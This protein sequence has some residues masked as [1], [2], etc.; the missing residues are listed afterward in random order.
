MGFYFSKIY[1]TTGKTMKDRISKLRFKNYKMMKVKNICCLWLASVLVLF[2]GCRHKAINYYAVSDFEKVPKIDAHFHYN[3]PDTR[4]LEYAN[5]L[6]FKLI[7]PNVNASVPIDDQLEIASVIKKRFPDKFTF[8]GTFSVDSFINAGFVD[9]TI[10]RIEKCMKAGASGI[11]IWKNI[12]MALKDTA[13]RFVMADDPAF[14]PVFNYLQEKH[15]PVLAHLG[16]PRNCWL[17]LEEMTL[18]NDHNYFKNHP[19]YHMYLHPEA[20]SYEDQINARD[21]LLLQYPK[22]NFTSAHLASLEWNVDELAKRFDRFPKMEADMA[23]RIG[24]LQ[25]QSLANREKVRN[26]LIK[27]QDRLMYA[28]DKTIGRDDINYSEIIKGLR[29]TW[30]NDWIYLATD[31]SVI[32]NELGQKEVK[33]LKLS[34][35]VID[36]IY[37]KNAERFY[38]IRKL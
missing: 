11:K 7:S 36:K 5:S 13:G 14:E 22:L 31:S 4:Y 23:E 25:Y 32:V 35:E 29:A 9:R 18:G 2:G 15:I 26:F 21:N 12:G 33:G 19:Q 20:P 28:T 10:A 24:H 30:V 16:E 6:N 27:Y 3:T 17:P 34:C 37:F 38:N 1:S 8:L